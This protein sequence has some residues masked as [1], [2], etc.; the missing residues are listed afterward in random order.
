MDA[1]KQP[2]R[3][4]QPR[5]LGVWWS[6][7]RRITVVPPL[8]CL[9]LHTCLFLC[10][11]DPG[12]GAFALYFDAYF[13]RGTSGHSATYGNEVLASKETFKCLAVEVWGFV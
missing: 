3:A 9:C 2:V 10:A 12:G 5:S 11:H 13:E 7:P 4:S 8:L 6:V 1:R